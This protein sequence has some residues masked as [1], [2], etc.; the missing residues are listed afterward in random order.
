MLEVQAFLRNA[1]APE[2]GYALLEDIYRVG[3]KRHRSYPNLVLLKYNHFGSPWEERIVQECRGV[4]LDEDDDFKVVSM[5][6]TKFFNHGESHA[7][8]IDWHTARVWEKVDGSLITLY[9]YNGWQVA[10]SGTPDA[11][12]DINGL[13]LTFGEMFWETITDMEVDVDI[14]SP[15][16]SYMFEL[17]APEN[18]VVVLHQERKLYLHGVRDLTTLHEER[19]DSWSRVSGVPLPRSWPLTSVDQ[20]VEAAEELEPLEQEGYVVCDADFNR[21]KVKSP[22]YVAIHH[23]KNGILSERNAANIIR[24]GES[25]EFLNYF[26]HYARLAAKYFEL[27]KSIQEAW[28]VNR[29][30]NDQKEFALRV[31]NLPYSGA[32]FALKA[33][34]TKSAEDYIARLTESAYHRL[35]EVA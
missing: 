3:V 29:H 22:R 8:P 7:T 21:I 6:Y 18:Q 32:L 13:D 35:L 30:I 28:E 14:F 34:K 4:I 17:C 1:T 11:A 33:G 16:H 20:V 25:S 12:T 5:G 24:R 9:W 2:I 23:A 31:K 26:P 15:G 10:T 27:V 19:P